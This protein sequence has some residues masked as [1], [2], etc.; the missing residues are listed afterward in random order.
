MSSR[1]SSAPPIRL[2][3][4]FGVAAFGWGAMALSGTWSNSSSLVMAAQ[5]L[6]MLGLVLATIFRGEVDDKRGLCAGVVLALF[7]WALAA[8]KMV[9]LPMVASARD[10]GAGPNLIWVYALLP[11]FLG[12][13]ALSGGR[14]K[15]VHRALFL[16]GI[17]VTGNGKLFYGGLVPGFALLL[18]AL[19]FVA[20]LLAQ[21]DSLTRLWSRWRS[22]FGTPLSIVFLALPLWW[23]IAGFFG[24]DQGAGLRVGFRLLIPAMVAIAMVRGLDRSGEKYLFGGF[25][26]GLTLAVGLAILGVA[27]AAEVYPWSVVQGSRLRVIGLHPNLGGALL[28]MGLPLAIAWGFAVRGAGKLQR[29]FGALLVLFVFGALLWTGSRA[30]LLGACVGVFG[31]PLILRSKRQISWVL[32]VVAACLGLALVLFATPLGDPLRDSLDSKALTQSA[33]GQRWHI[34]KM[35]WSA[36]M[37]NPLTGVGPLSFHAHSAFAESSYYDGTSQTLHTHNIFLGA[38]A[39]AGLIGLA[40]FVSYIFGLFEAGRR[41]LF[42]KSGLCQQDRGLPAA[43]LS[44]L[45]VLAVCNQ[46]DLGQSQVSFLPMFFWIALGVFGARLAKG[47]APAPGSTSSSSLHAVAALALWPAMGSTILGA[48]LVERAADQADAGEVQRAVETYELTLGPWSH[49]RRSSVE[50]ALSALHMRA[51]NKQGRIATWEEATTARPQLADVWIS[52]A[53]AQLAASLWKEADSSISRA[54]ELDPR[55]Q[56]AAWMWMIAAQCA[57]EMGDG[58]YARTCLETAIAGGQ[59][60]RSGMRIRRDESGAI[61]FPLR[62]K[63]AAIKLESVID[64]IGER[65]I[66]LATTDPISS[67]RLM[68]GIV[69]G[70]RANNDLE[71]ALGWA[72]RSQRALDAPQRANFMLVF[73]LL[74]ELGRKAEAIAEWKASP[75]AAEPNLVSLYGNK[76]A[77]SK[78]SNLTLD[79]FFTAG[80]LS[81]HHMAS[82]KSYLSLGMISS[83]RHELQAALYNTPVDAIRFVEH[84]EYLSS[85]QEYGGSGVE[86]EEELGRFWRSLARRKGAQRDERFLNGIAELLR[87]EYG[88]DVAKIEKAA[89]AIVDGDADALAA[90]LVPAE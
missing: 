25:I 6:L 36:T 2:S 23:L 50:R 62:G 18:G 77:Q 65:M 29:G 53:E 89:R 37:D 79:I 55:G 33:L 16:L 66:G 51:K 68:M 84:L 26:F 5:V 17:W 49:V 87:A 72:R 81:E 45:L 42:A 30:S 76:N 70:C 38:S 13:F 31:L 43:M 57:L 41:T 20:L 69:A 14:H 61:S 78:T 63:N 15:L 3:A 64:K 8:E 9:H 4:L 47:Q 54:L 83:A 90:L 39:G 82:A 86:L 19:L 59:G 85:L 12:S 80:I 28:A 40:L 73:D 35:A 71:A 58:K 27:E 32:P 7:S 88:Q 44:A 48:G 24:D 1:T 67:R 46:L 75:W 11:M 21:G 56:T 52:L 60:P 22:A 74:R 34:W 10:F